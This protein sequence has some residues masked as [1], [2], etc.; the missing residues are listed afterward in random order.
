MEEKTLKQRNLILRTMAKAR[1]EDGLE[2]LWIREITRRTGLNMGTVTWVLYRYLTPDYVEFPEV[3]AL[4]Q[5]GLKI[6]PIKLKD[7][8]YNQMIGKGKG[9]EEPKAE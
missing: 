9:K 6:R 2:F 7:N 4:L 1:A 3:D 8:I 5:K